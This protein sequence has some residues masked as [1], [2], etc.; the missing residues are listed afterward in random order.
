M[1]WTLPEV[2]ENALVGCRF[3]TVQIQNALKGVVA[4]S[5]V[6]EDLCAMLAEQ[7]L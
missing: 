1:D 5:V 2:I 3:D 7:V 4:D 6:Q